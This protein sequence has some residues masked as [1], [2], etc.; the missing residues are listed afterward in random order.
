MNKFYYAL[1]LLSL[2]F[3]CACGQNDSVSI[4]QCFKA[5]RENATLKPQLDI[6]S[7]I[8]DLKIENAKSTNLPELSAYG[9]AWYQSDA[10]AVPSPLPNQ[11]G[12]EI[13][14]FQYNFGLEVDQKIYDGGMARKSKQLETVSVESDKNK[15]ET[16][17][18]K[19]NDRINAYFF[20]S[21]FYDE[22]R[23]TLELKQG[24]LEKR[25]TEMESAVKNGYVKKSESDKIIAESL[26][27]Q[28]QLL[29]LEKS[30]TQT[31]MALQILTGLN[32][33]DNARL[34][35]PD[36]INI[37]TQAVRP[38]IRYFDSEA[39]KIDKSV[40]LKSA[41]NL[42]KF[43]AYGQL[44]YSYPG[45]NFF[46]NMP[47]YYYIIGA[48]LSWTILDWKQV[49]RETQV[50]RKQGD[51]IKTQRD[52]F[53]RNLVISATNEQVEQ[54]KLLQILDVDDQMI[55]K[56]ASITASS[57]SA[58]ANGVITASSYID[59]LNAEIKARID[60]NTHKIQYQN[61]IVKSYLL[62]G[63]DIGH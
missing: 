3:S 49:N 21:L 14:K 2:I 22:N 31:L 23:K 57:A 30:K 17:L 20:A 15:V 54:Q 4:I 48:K 40:S 45:L 1:S 36:S 52:D 10:I 35:I 42:P 34:F 32:L 9:K 58:L 12:F 43:Y 5:G 24:Y 46:E 7:A 27:T 29:E 37:F 8:A 25:L 55:K 26:L 6:F 51:L 62:A 28:Q 18:Y 47:N 56:R 41:Q 39:Q 63:I 61:S 53:T 33:S 50:L 44:G 19:L 13:D 60:M 11:S 16:D 38:E 59:D